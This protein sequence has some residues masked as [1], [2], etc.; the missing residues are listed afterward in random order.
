MH[1][2]RTRILS[3]ALSDR[4]D[5]R[6]KS[7]SGLSDKTTDVGPIVDGGRVDAAWGSVD[8]DADRIGVPSIRSA[9]YLRDPLAAVTHFNLRSI[10]F[11][12]WMSE[13]ER[14]HYLYGTMQSFVDLAKLLGIAQGDLGLGGRLSIALGARGSGPGL[15][16]YEPLDHVV[17][18]LTKG[19]K[20]E[21]QGKGSFA[22]EYGHA[23]DN[24][25]AVLAGEP[26]RVYMSGGGSIAHTINQKRAATK[27]FPG[28][29]ERLFQ[30]LYW[31]GS[32]ERSW[33]KKLRKLSGYYNRR[34]EVFARTFETWIAREMERQGIENTW[35]SEPGSGRVQGVSI[36]PPTELI[37]EVDP[38]LR[39]ILRDAFKLFAKHRLA[40]KGRTV[41]TDPDGE[42]L[43]GTKEPPKDDASGKPPK[44]P[45]G[46]GGPIVYGTKTVI[47]T[48]TK[49]IPARYAV[50][51]LSRLIASHN[52]E[53]FAPNANYPSLCQQRD[54]THD[55]AEQRKVQQN[56][57]AFDPAFL[58]ANAPTATDGPPVVNRSMVVLGGNSRTM[59]LSLLEDY[60]VYKNYLVEHANIYGIDPS[61]LD[62]F[63]RPVLVREVDIDMSECA[64]YSNILNKSLTQEIDIT[65]EAVSYA[66]QL[67]KGALDDL[68]E[69]FEAAETDTLAEA[70]RD[71]P[72]AHHVVKVFRQVGI[73]NDQNVSQWLDPATQNLSDLGRLTV[74]KVLVANVLTDKELID[75]V[76][77]YTSLIAKNV[78]LLIRM[79]AIGGEWD[80]TPAIEEAIRQE[81]KRR[82]DGTPREQFIRQK[83]AFSEDVREGV[84]TVWNA[85]ERPRLFKTFLDTYVSQAERES[86]ESFG[87]DEP[88]TP[89]ELLEK[90]ATTKGLSGLDCP[91]GLEDDPEESDI[92]ATMPPP[93]QEA[94]EDDRPHKEAPDPEN[95]L[96]E[97][98]VEPPEHPPSDQCTVTSLSDIFAL[99]G[100]P[101]AWSPRWKPLM[102]NLPAGFMMLVWGWTG[103]GKST[104]AMDLA[105]EIAR[106]GKVL[107]AT[108]E[109]K[110][111]AGMLAER[112]RLIRARSDS[113]FFTND[114]YPW[115][116]LES[117]ID[118]GGYTFVIL[119]SINYLLQQKD[120][121][122]ETLVKL[123]ERHP[124]VAFI[125]IAFSDKEKSMFK[126]D[127]LFGFA[128]D[129]I[130][131]VHKGMARLEKNKY[132]TVDTAPYN[133]FHR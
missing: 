105:T 26:R 78:P 46:T 24:M 125:F 101:L 18:N 31:D 111:E 29:Y 108:A 123:R 98:P 20:G 11:G 122:I 93:A 60:S 13:T 99:T 1:T 64:T 40:R 133:V 32:K 129:I 69:R 7:K 23:I 6:K 35:L 50:T 51:D 103:Q 117:T 75:A 34:E 76:P 88:M 10:E 87:F 97:P 82:R 44:P 67:T 106:F 53:T 127:S 109:E 70:L 112:A 95:P 72:T 84:V 2:F 79:Q 19:P 74:E 100:Q 4:L 116:R 55:K 68:A 121:E 104:F 58:V 9:P 65:T 89:A 80:L 33:S 39:E 56:A 15:A 124:G 107:Y 41:D 48:R 118:A 30:T 17:I 77:S 71:T 3:P 28:S 21:F 73:I 130:V 91:C 62:H 36:Y 94:P 132:G 12:N 47:N 27:G 114:T 14:Q 63:E 59:S 96:T 92:I 8:L 90:I 42:Q 54:Y 119:D 45:K 120:V 110:L 5:R 43:P 61:G 115:P 85:L 131:H 25:I 66:R 37:V 22:H 16:H 52:A 57:Q 49:K 81:A 128:S 113:V 86:Q 38:I 102:G 126:G 83:D